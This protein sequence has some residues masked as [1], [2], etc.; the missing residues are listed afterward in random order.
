[1]HADAAVVAEVVKARGDADQRSG[2]VERRRSR[3]RLQWP[4]QNRP[5]PLE[6]A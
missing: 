6:L 4:R 5:A 2:S 3:T 1:V